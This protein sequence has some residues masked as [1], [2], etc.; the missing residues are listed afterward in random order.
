MKAYRRGT[1]Y[2][3]AADEAQKTAYSTRKGQALT[4]RGLP[5]AREDEVIEFRFYQN[6]RDRSGNLGAD[7]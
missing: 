6:R 5:M 2:H 4:Q 1:A 7:N 3:E